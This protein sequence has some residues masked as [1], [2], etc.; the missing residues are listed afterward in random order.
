MSLKKEFASFAEQEGANIRALC[1]RFG[2]CPATGYKWLRRYQS[3]GEVGLAEHSRRPHASPKQTTPAQE[4]LIVQAAQAHPVWGARKLKAWLTNQGH[5]L[6]AASTVHAVLRRH[7]LHEAKERTDRA[8]K[9]FEHDAP[10]DL[11]QMDFKGHFET[12]AGR[13]HPL[14]LLDD[15]SRF[16]LCLAACSDERRE[17]VQNHLVRVFDLYGLPERMTM[18]NGAPWGDTTGRFTALELWLMRQG[19]RVG[20]SRPYHPQTQGKLERLHETLKAELLQGRHFKKNTQTQ[21]AFD[22]WRNG[23]NLERPHEALGQHSPASRYRPSPRSYVP[24]PAPPQ[25]GTHMQ[26][27]KVDAN[28]RLNFKGLALKVGKAFVRENL[29]LREDA[30]DGIYSLWWYSTNIGRID[31]KQRSVVVGKSV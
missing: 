12:G 4:D 13:C 1:R 20:H 8:V 2:I 27:R 7:G 9:R 18:D 22:A 14:T 17:T 19:I 23:Y 24:V 5:S 16:L 6:P 3:E 15:H 30:E 26:V 11:W 31:L 21:R 25:Y 29:G 28:G 10:N